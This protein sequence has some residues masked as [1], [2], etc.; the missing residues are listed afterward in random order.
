MQ[1][2]GKWLL[3]YSG[4]F[5]SSKAKSAFERGRAAIGAP[6]LLPASAA[7]SLAQDIAIAESEHYTENRGR[8]EAG[9]APTYHSRKASTHPE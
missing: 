2:R 9:L 8:N 4:M 6:V 5:L 7:A 1:I 3:S